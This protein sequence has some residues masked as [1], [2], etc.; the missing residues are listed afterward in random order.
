MSK[1]PTATLAAYSR[2][3]DEVTLPQALG[4]SHLMPLYTY[5]W[6]VAAWRAV[7][8]LVL[9]RQSWAKTDRLAEE[10]AA[11]PGL[12]GMQ[13]TAAGTSGRH[14]RGELTR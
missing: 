12:A 4:Y 5:M 6:Y 7:F 13:S 9:R 3:V 10:P 2:H 8:R 14:R 1:S 11:S